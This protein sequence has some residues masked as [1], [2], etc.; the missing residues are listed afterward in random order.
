MI[1]NV[2]LEIFISQD[3]EVLSFETRNKASIYRSFKFKNPFLGFQKYF[4]QS[5]VL[6][7]KNT[8]KTASST[9]PGDPRPNMY[10]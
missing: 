10:H 9:M 3:R 5:P 7:L 1:L 8:D 4:A 2:V 6:R